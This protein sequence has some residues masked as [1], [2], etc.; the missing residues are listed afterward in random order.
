GEEA[1]HATAGVAAEEGDVDA[2][3]DGGLDVLEHRQRIVF[4]VSDR[5]K[6]STAE[7]AGGIGGRIDVAD[8][9]DVVSVLLHPEGEGELPEEEL[10]GALREWCIEDLAILPVG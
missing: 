1:Q 6:P 9:A 10:A 2:R 7:Q 4:V 8:I 5:Q 3:G